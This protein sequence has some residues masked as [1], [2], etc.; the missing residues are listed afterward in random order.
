MTLIFV[1]SSHS[2]SSFR[3]R[4]FGA[5]P[6]HTDGELLALRFA[7]DGS[8]WSV[9]EPGVLRHWDV[10]S[11]QQLGWSELGT[12][13]AVWCFSAAAHYVAA[14]SDE[15]CL[16]ES[17]NGELLAF[18]N[19]ASWTTALAFQP[20]GLLLASGHDDGGVRLWDYTG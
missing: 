10:R 9:E 2:E 18:W 7:P 6:F 13:E 1:S 4:V 5:R 12:A 8:L 14:G 19:Q 11:R 3:P 15:L 20:G 17:T 16:W